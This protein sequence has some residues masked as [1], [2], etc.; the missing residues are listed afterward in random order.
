MNRLADAECHKL[1]TNLFSCASS[2]SHCS[3]GSSGIRFSALTNGNGSLTTAL[4]R[5]ANRN[6]NFVLV[7]SGSFEVDGANQLIEIVYDL[8]IEAIQL[9][10][11]AYFEFGVSAVGLK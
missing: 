1:H 5:Y 8:L 11:L 9:G 3:S 7:D 4:A 10:S 6:G 2:Q